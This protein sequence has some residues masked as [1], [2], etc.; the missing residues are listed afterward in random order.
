MEYDPLPDIA[1]ALS[2][3]PLGRA[4]SEQGGGSGFASLPRRSEP[5]LPNY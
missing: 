3:S 4:Q 1:G 5:L 2:R